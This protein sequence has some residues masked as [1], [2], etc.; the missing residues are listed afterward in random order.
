MEVAEHRRGGE[1]PRRSEEATSALS[2]GS[3]L[4]LSGDNEQANLS[5]TGS[6][7][8]LSAATAAG[9]VMCV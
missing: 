1:N 8:P 5:Q 7:A 3:Q 4:R 6:S 9:V 2:R